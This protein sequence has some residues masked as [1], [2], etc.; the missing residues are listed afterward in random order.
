VY[1]KLFAVR[2]QMRAKNVGDVPDAVLEDALAQSGCSPDEAEAIYR[3]TSLP[4]VEQ[5]FVLPP[6]TR[7]VSMEELV[8]PY[9]RKQEAGFG[10]VQPAKRRW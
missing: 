8:D 7:E 1:R 5:R 10:F 6:G 3:L 4:T 9:N 2:V